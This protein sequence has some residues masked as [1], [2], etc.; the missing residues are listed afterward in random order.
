MACWKLNC[1]FSSVRQG[2]EFIVVLKLN[3]KSQ[4]FANNA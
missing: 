3:T 1:A 4:D 2:F